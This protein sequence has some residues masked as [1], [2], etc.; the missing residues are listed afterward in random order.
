MAEARYQ[1]NIT[2]GASVELDEEPDTDSI[3]DDLQKHIATWVEPLRI[4]LDS[5]QVDVVSQPLG[6]NR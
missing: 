4:T 6:G 1:V 3:K 5:F 2:F